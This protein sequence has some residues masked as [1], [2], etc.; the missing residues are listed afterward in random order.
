MVKACVIWVCQLTCS[1]WRKVF[2]MYDING[3]GTVQHDEIVAI[4]RRKPLVQVYRIPPLCF[5]SADA[6]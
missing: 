5:S 3:D 4:L 1:L 2:D 6:M